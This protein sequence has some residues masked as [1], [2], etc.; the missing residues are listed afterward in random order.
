MTKG[1]DKNQRENIIFAGRVLIAS[2]P[3]KPAIRSSTILDKNM[4]IISL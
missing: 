1:M 2:V 3:I 4:E